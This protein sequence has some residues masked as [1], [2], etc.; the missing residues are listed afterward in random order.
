MREGAPRSVGALILF[1]VYK[2]VRKRSDIL[3][4]YSWCTHV[5]TCYFFEKTQTIGQSPGFNLVVVL[6]YYRYVYIQPVVSSP[7]NRLFPLFILAAF[8]I[9]VGLTPVSAQQEVVYFYEEGCPQ[10]RVVSSILGELSKE[11]SLNVITYDVGTPEGYSLFTEY[12]FTTTPALFIHGKKMEG[13]ITTTDIVNALQRSHEWYHFVLALILGLVSGLSPS[14]MRVHADIISEVAR[15]T[16]EETDV[17]MRSLLFCVGIFV[18]AFCL[19]VVVDGVE[20]F[21]FLAVLLG[22]AVSVNLLNSGLHSFNSYTSIDLYIKAKFIALDAGSVLKLGFLHGIG[23]FSDSVPLFVP[24]L[25]LG[26]TRGHFLQD[27]ILVVLFCAGIIVVYVI[28]LVLAI[29][30]IN[31][32]K[33]LKEE[34]F[35]K[36]FFSASGLVVITTSVWLL[37][38]I[39]GEVAVGVAVVLT[40]VVI[41]VSGV[42]IGFKRRIIY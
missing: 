13:I 19:F 30:Q 8:S 16:R 2:E 15:T 32:F 17:V 27:F 3:Y 22:L 7:M 18:C 11:Y 40:L 1:I 12:G 6:T 31:L 14:L 36:V 9:G 29:M 23:K 34:S 10:C 39:L 21:H 26:I 37:W 38:E 41:A 5:T 42:L 25:F 4:F 28:L 24:L 33:K 35:S 20:G